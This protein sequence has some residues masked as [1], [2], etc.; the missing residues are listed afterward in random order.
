MVVSCYLRKWAANHPALIPDSH[1]PNLN[2]SFDKN[3]Y[4]KTL[5]F[6]LMEKN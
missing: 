6:F 4:T 5:G 2:I 1:E 3:A